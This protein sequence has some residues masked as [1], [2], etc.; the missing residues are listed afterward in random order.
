[1][2]ISVSTYSFA[3]MMED[4]ELTQIGC[5]Q[6]AKELGFDAIEIESIR[7]HDGSTDTE[8]AYALAK[9]AKRLEMPLSNFTFGADFLHGSEGNLE[10]EIERVKRLVDIAEILG[11]PSIRHDATR[12]YDA[13]TRH[14]RGFDEALPTLIKGC[15]A[16]TEYASTKGIRTMVEN[17]G[18]FCQDSR[19]VEKLVTGVAHSNFGL[20]VDMGNFLCVDEDPVEAFSRTAPYAYYAHAKDFH[21]KSGMGPNPGKGFFKSRGGNYLR[22]AIIG[23]GNVPVLQCINI[24][25]QVGYEGYIAIEFEGMEHPIKGLE[26]GL[27]NLKNYISSKN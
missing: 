20:L 6:K 21:V 13:Q 26:V 18:M 8:Y 5:L 11:V 2:K 27:E 9:E 22:G 17:H 4:G 24:L 25:K 16:I 15:R 14:P 10:K 19:R 23:H 7:P 12:G 3:K 1:M